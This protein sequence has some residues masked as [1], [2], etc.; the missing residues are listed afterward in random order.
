MFLTKKAVLERLVGLIGK[1]KASLKIET[2]ELNCAVYNDPAIVKGFAQIK[3][4]V[5]ITVQCSGVICVDK[6]GHNNII[7]LW[8]QGALELYTRKVR[9]NKIHRWIADETHIYSEDFHNPC[10][11]VKERN[12]MVLGSEQEENWAKKGS[13]IF[14]SKISDN[15][16]K[17]ITPDMKNSLVLLEADDIRKLFDYFAEKGD[18]YNYKTVEEIEEAR[19]QLGI[20]RHGL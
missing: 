9:G 2:G 7:D 15:E 13:E 6:E 18:D 14:M 19:K 16:L 10:V 5:Q 11:D 4:K 20:K 8:K 12:V 17:K 1:V 3:N